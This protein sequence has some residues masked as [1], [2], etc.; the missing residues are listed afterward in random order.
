MKNKQINTH[1]ILDT[2]VKFRKP[3]SSLC[4]LVCSKLVMW[5]PTSYQVMCSWEKSVSTDAKG[6]QEMCVIS[7][8]CGLG[9]Q[10]V[11]RTDVSPLRLS[12][13][14]GDLYPAFYSHGGRGNYSW[15]W[16][17]VNSE[18]AE[19]PEGGLRSE[20]SV[21]PHT[22]LCEHSCSSASVALQSGSPRR[23][24]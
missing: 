5:H 15:M 10:R 17:R 22:K 8:V 23:G 6:D 24:L 12:P 11:G 16:C 18:R 7:D 21:G 20:S 4:H 13:S 2:S 9:E 14:D 1:T 3:R 19:G